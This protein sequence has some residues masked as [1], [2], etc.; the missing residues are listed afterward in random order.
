MNKASTR[1]SIV[2]LH[3]LEYSSTEPV[4]VS[5]SLVVHSDLTWMI[6]VHDHVVD[7]LLSSVLSDLP[8]TMTIHTFK[9]L[10]SRKS[11]VTCV[12]GI[13]MK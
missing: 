4:V 11:A 1:L 10:V 13:L 3:H 2:K 5:V 8:S 12:S 6:H 9:G 7:P